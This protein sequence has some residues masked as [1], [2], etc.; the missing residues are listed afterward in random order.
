MNIV[1]VD[2]FAH[3]DAGYEINLLT[4]LQVKQGHQVTIV[5][6]EL[7][8]LPT[9]L[10]NF[11][12]RDNIA[13]RDERFRRETGVQIVRIPLHAYYSGRAL[14]HRTIYSAIEAIA[15]DVTFVHGMESVIG[16]EFA[17]RARSL[18]YPIVLDSHSVEMASVNRLRNLFRVV[19]KTFVAPA[20]IKQD[21]PVIRIVDSDYVEKCLGVPLSHTTLLSFGTDTDFFQPDKEARA[22]F[23]AEHAIPEDAF[24]VLYAGKLDI[25][26]GGQ[27]LAEAVKAQFA[28]SPRRE[29]VFIVVGNIDGSYG[30]NVEKT[31]SASAN[32][33]LRFSTQRY[34]D[35]ARFYQAADLALFPKQCS[36]SFFEAQACGLPVL[37]EENEINVQRTAY[38]NALTFQPGSVEDFRA[39]LM[40]L[41]QMSPEKYSAMGR[42][43]RRYVADNYNY[44]PIAQKFTDVLR[45]AIQKWKKR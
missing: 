44:V 11:F 13:E 28:A 45:L 2:D 27:L 21:I 17:L 23:R 26:K 12:G 35:L 16:M 22:Q 37:F 18:P 25:G 43:A 3:P 10:T 29:I 14:F 36:V 15:P 34:F 38:G 39:K 4:R 7:N 24:L 5:A 42:E 30:E 41:W 8:K 19:Y 33:I 31:F 9:T 6:G 1:H 20:I 32:R 40:D